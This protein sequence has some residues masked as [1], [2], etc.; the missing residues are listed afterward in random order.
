MSTERFAGSRT[1]LRR[2]VKFIAE[3]NDELE[4]YNKRA[5][6]AARLDVTTDPPQIYVEWTG[7]S[8]D[9]GAMLGD[10]IHNLRTSLDLMACEL[11]RIN[12]ESDK[13]VHFPFADSVDRIDD[14]IKEKKFSRAG[15]DAVELLKEF[16][17]YKGGNVRLR[18]IHD[19]D[20]SDKHR[21]VLETQKSIRV[22]ISGSYDLDDL[23]R[24]SIS[25]EASTIE[26]FFSPDS[27]LAD[28]PVIPTLND[29]VALVEKIVDGFE[30]LVAKRA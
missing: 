17:P 9:A 18:A 19:L 8:L 30:L 26:H 20:V 10:A 27:A 14:Q 24:H 4:A 12:N 1:K 21:A 15:A 11:V 6:T 16:A 28:L 25:I 13:G 22:E 2:A 29:L 5:L 23:S 3:L 7:L